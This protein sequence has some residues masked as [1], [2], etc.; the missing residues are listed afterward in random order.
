[1]GGGP[2]A[3]DRRPG[4]RER[5]PA[6]ADGGAGA[7]GR[8]RRLRRLLLVAGARDEPRAAV[9]ARTGAAAAELAPP[10]DRLPRPGRLDRRLRHADRPTVG[11]AAGVRADRGARHRARARVRHR[12]RQAARHA[13]PAS[14][15]RASTSSASCLSTIG[16]RAT[17]SAGSTSRS[18][19]SWASRSR[20]RSRRGSLRWPRW[21]PTSCRRARR[22]RS[23]WSTCGRPGDWALDIALEVELNGDAHQPHERARAVLD[24]PAAARA[25]DR[26]RRDRAPRRPVRLRDDLGRRRPAARGR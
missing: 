11:A 14:T 1:M 7:A 23:R 12:P 19:R 18:G 5:R 21:S 3:G 26:Q 15:R 2:R 16:A 8:G 25:R 20:R 6:A 9:P 10:A 4:G 17:S 13:D 24:V 22:I